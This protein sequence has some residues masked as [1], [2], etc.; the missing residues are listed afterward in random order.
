MSEAIGA[1]NIP[2]LHHLRLQLQV[3]DTNEDGVTISD[4]PDRM[5]RIEQ[6]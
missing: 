2:L 1:R 4:I 6:I 5:Q 3:A